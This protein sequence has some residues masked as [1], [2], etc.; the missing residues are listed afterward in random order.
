MATARNHRFQLGTSSPND[1]DRT[2]LW[3]RVA[4]TRVV[5]AG[6]CSAWRSRYRRQHNRYLASEKRRPA[7]LGRQLSHHRRDLS[8]PSP[9]SLALG[10][11]RNCDTD[12]FRTSFRQTT[13]VFAG[14]D[15]FLG[16][17]LCGD[18]G[19]RTYCRP[20]CSERVLRFETCVAQLSPAVRTRTRFRTLPST[21]DVVLL[22]TP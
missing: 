12:I 13:R 3:S 5:G 17:Q 2:F 11:P 7:D 8:T 22:K 21:E 4:C 1:R 9:E 18:I 19:E 14:D 6:A 10:L 16:M 15:S 20:F